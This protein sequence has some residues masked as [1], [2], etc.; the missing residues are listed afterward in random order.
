M[1]DAMDP[2]GLGILC[3]GRDKAGAL[4]GDIA[5][6]KQFAM[7]RQYVF[8]CVGAMVDDIAS[9]NV[10]PNPY[11]RGSNRSPCNYCP[12]VALCASADLQGRRNFASMNSDRFWEEVEKEV[13]HG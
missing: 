10:E 1:I 11:T 12:Y 5:D 3:C 13:R 7:L 8:S 6:F 9:G 2:N 4:K